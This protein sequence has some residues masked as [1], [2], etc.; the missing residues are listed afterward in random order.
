MT[1]RCPRDKTRQHT[2]K[3]LRGSGLTV[4]MLNGVV[5]GA[6]EGECA[7]STPKLSR[8]VCKL[9]MSVSSWVDQIRAC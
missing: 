2:V 8:F 4:A 5:N 7:A 6:T 9:V 1:S 3:T